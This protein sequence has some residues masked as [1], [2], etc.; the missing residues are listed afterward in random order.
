MRLSK[1]KP[2]GAISFSV[3]RPD[4]PR[5]YRWSFRFRAYVRRFDLNHSTAV[6]YTRFHNYDPVEHISTDW[7]YTRQDIMEASNKG[8]Q[9]TG[10]SSP[11]R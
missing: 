8:I 5:A 11:A 1:L 3:P 6:R 9:R 4:K 2:H 7:I 10:D